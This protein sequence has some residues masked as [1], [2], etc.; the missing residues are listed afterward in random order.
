[1]AFLH[2]SDY[3]NAIVHIDG[4]CFFAS[5][6]I[7]KNPA[8]RGKPV[9]TG[10]ERGIVSSLSYEAK[11]RGV[12][13]SM[14]LF[15]VKKICPDVIMI[16]SDY[17][18][19]SL[20][21]M[22]MYAIVRRYTSEVEEYSID[23]CFADLTGLQRPLGKSYEQIAR[24]IQHDLDT[25]LGMTFSVGLAPTKVLAKV[26]S[27]WNKPCGFT[28][29]TA[30]DAPTFLKQLPVEKIWGIGPQTT[31]YFRKLGIHTAF[32]YSN[33]S[34]EWIENNLDKPLRETWR[35]LNSELVFP[36]EITKRKPN[37]TISKTKTFEK[38]SDNKEFV[39]SQLSKNIENACIKA[40]RH[41]LE[42]QKVHI[43]L[44]TQVFT[45]TGA[46]VVLNRKTNISSDVISAVRPYFETLWVSQLYR[47]TGVVLTDLKVETSQQMDLFCDI[48]KIDKAKR[49]YGAI[50]SVSK[51]FGKHTLFLGS[52]F[53]SV[54]K[55][56][57]QQSESKILERSNVMF[58]GETK[59]KKIY[60]PLLG[61][62][63]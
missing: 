32:D 14:P 17:E 23:E 7:A 16:P 20:Y 58:K 37:Q 2:H 46:E 59:R 34:K 15:E 47:A 1:M 35:E 4:D 51:K 29:I 41:N 54:S 33:T 24:C 12:T 62:T 3:P 31:A 21:S 49:L 11:R 48:L 56:T 38:P 55:S 5:C 22:R 30:K 26:G 19:Y 43:H 63:Y 57:T 10:Y 53:L 61:Y 39:F 6:E 18:T 36:I 27:K 44:K 45:Y 13:R 42:F 40:R 52:S 28:A 9:I 50:D 25:E 60:I 8:L